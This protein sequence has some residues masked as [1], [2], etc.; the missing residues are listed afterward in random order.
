MVERTAVVVD[1]TADH[2][3]VARHAAFLADRCPTAWLDAAL[4]PLQTETILARRRGHHTGT[5]SIGC[6]SLDAAWRKL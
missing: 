1:G 3:T 5:V 2:G 6:A 4:S